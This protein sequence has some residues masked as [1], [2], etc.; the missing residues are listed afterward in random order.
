MSHR[1]LHCRYSSSLGSCISTPIGKRLTLSWMRIVMGSNLASAIPNGSDQPRRTNHQPTNAHQLS[2]CTWL[3]K[4][5]RAGWQACSTP[6]TYP[7][8]KSAASVSFPKRGPEGKWCLI[9]DLFFPTGSSVN[10]GIHRGIYP[11]LNH[12]DQVIQLVSQLGPGVP[13]G[14]F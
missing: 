3:I 7:A 9:V 11:P 10:D 8:S 12:V 5:L 14:K 6:L 2:M 13:M 1:S 4:C